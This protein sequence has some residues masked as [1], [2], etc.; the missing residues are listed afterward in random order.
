MVGV[1]GV[2]M[3]LVMM[4]VILSIRGVVEDCHV[5]GDGDDGDCGVV[6]GGDVHDGGDVDG[7][8]DGGGYGVAGGDDACNEFDDGFGDSDGDGPS[9]VDFD[10]Y[11]GCHEVGDVNNGVV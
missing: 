5:D 8:G 11:S 6:N 2:V 3:V 9:G 7:R 4:L 10:I 1:M